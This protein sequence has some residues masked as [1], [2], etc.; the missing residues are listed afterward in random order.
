MVSTH[1]SGNK[2]SGTKYLPI[3][4][5]PQ[6]SPNQQ[7]LPLTAKVINQDF[8][9]IGG[10]DVITLVKQFGSPL[11]I[12]DETTLRNSC[13]RYRDTFQHYYQ[14]ESQV[15]YAS[16][17]WSCLAVCMIAASEGLGIDVVSAGELHTAITAGVKPTLIYFHGNNKSLT[18]LVFALEVG[19]NIVVDNWHE[20][21]TLINLAKERLL[22]GI[23]I[24]LRLAPGIECHTHEYIRTGNLDSKFGFNPNDLDELFRLI[25]QQKVLNCVGL[26]AHIGS[27]IFECQPHRDLAGV[28]TQWLNKARENG[29]SIN[30]L[31]VGGGLGIKYTESDDPPS[32]EE[33]SKAICEVVQKACKASNLPLPKLLCEP[34][35]SLIATACVTAYTI[36]S[37]KIVPGIRTYLAIDGGMSDN[38]R[39]ITYQSLYTSVVANRMSAPVTETV[40]IAGKHCESGDIVIKH[41][42]LPQVEPGDILVIMGTGAY[43][44]SMAS[45]YNRVPRPAAIIVANSEANL[46]LQRETL[47]D[48]IQKDCLPERLRS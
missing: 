46:I 13:S 33:W 20:L 4:N 36:G 17:A 47:Q 26:H 19:C 45:N 21:N 8:L 37:Y 14:G 48:L 44:Y 2:H 31:N 34:G 11:Y 15:L 39:T 3:T 42:H 38:P 22:S 32:I 7:L 18:E 25:I 30:Q 10:C 5:D 28:M 27:Q 41:A 29:L 12:L 40:T 43:N 1:T 6:I 24:M 23:P 16:K 35:R 9:E